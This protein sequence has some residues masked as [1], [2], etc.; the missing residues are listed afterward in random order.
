MW[1][2]ISKNPL[3]FENSGV[4]QSAP[5]FSRVL[6]VQRFFADEI[7]GIYSSQYVTMF[8]TL[9]PTIVSNFS[10]HH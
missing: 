6:K 3:N 2:N 4:L 9:L 1:G 7:D 5:E 10:E 8:G